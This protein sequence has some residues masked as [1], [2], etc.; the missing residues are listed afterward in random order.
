MLALPVGGFHTVVASGTET[1]LAQWLAP[2]ATWLSQLTGSHTLIAQGLTVEFR[3]G[4]VIWPVIIVFIGRFMFAMLRLCMPQK[5]APGK[6]LRLNQSI[7]HPTWRLVSNQ[8]RLKQL[9]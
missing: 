2:M 9:R 5:N 1:N 8:S 3:T 7:N 6:R 4:Y